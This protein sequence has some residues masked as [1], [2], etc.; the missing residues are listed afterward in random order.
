MLFAGDI[1]FIDIRLRIQL[2]A[3]IQYLAKSLT[4]RHHPHPH[5]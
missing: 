5:S 3:W 2:E 4:H 1:D